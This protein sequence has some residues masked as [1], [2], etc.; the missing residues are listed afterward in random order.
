MAYSPACFQ[1]TQALRASLMSSEQHAGL[2]REFIEQQRLRA[3]CGLRNRARPLAR[4]E[5]DQ[6]PHD[7]GD[8]V[9]HCSSPACTAAALPAGGGVISIERSMN[10][11]RRNFPTYPCSLE[12]HA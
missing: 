8:E 1:S 6:M 11:V 5:I 9:A 4:Y 2:G 10:R 3:L 12:H 7:A